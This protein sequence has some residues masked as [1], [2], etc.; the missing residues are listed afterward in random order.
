LTYEP[1]KS[2]L[3]ARIRYAIL[4]GTSARKQVKLRDVSAPAGASITLLGRDDNLAWLQKGQNLAVTLPGG[5][6][7]APAHALRITPIV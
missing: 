7:D 6:P 2:S 3:R 4:L 1:A 5:L